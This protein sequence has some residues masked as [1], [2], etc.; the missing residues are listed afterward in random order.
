LQREGVDVV[1]RRAGRTGT[2]VV[3]LDQRG[4]RTMLT[5]RGAASQLDRPDPA[6]LDGLSAL[7]IPFYSL[8][9]DPLAT[10]ART[11]AGWAHERG[12]TVSVDASSAAAL[13]EVGIDAAVDLLTSLPTDVLFCNELEAAALGDE[14]VPERFGG[15]F[16]VVKHGR[17]PAVVHQPG[18]APVEVA[19]VEIG[20]VTDTTGA[21]DSFAAGVLVALA[22]GASPTDAV[23]AGH[24]TAARYIS[25]ASNLA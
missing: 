9:S 1:A 13:R 8:L 20:G 14:V 19:A 16:S 18:L 25:A 3:L 11:L 10:T 15:R 21:G 6:W 4:E 24:H 12:I 23:A 7:H 22:A 5:D 2:I 17:A